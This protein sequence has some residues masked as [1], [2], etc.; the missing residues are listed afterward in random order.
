MRDDARPM[1]TTGQAVRRDSYHGLRPGMLVGGNF[2]LLRQVGAG[3]SGTVWEAQD[4]AQGRRVA[5]KLLLSQL[6]TQDECIHRMRS[7]ARIMASLKHPNI[8]TVYT[9][10]KR[11]D[12]SFFVVQELLEG[13]T[14]REHLFSKKHLSVEETL[15]LVIPMVAAL[16]VVHKQGVLHRDIKP[17]NIFLSESAD[18]RFSPKLIDFGIA[19]VREAGNAQSFLEKGMLFGTLDYMAP[20]Q[21]R[22]E[23]LD[24]RAD[25]WA[26]GVVLFEMLTGIMPF[27][28]STPK[29]VTQKINSGI[30]PSVTDYSPDVPKALVDIV[31]AALKVDLPWRLSSMKAFLKKLIEFS[32]SVN[33]ELVT[34]HAQSL[35]DAFTLPTKKKNTAA[36]ASRIQPKMTSA[37]LGRADR[38]GAIEAIEEI[39]SSFLVEAAPDPL[40]QTG[41][42]PDFHLVESG[43]TARGGGAATTQETSFEF[44]ANAAAEALRVNLL[45]EAVDHAAEA[46]L[47]YDVKGEPMG[48]LLLVEAIASFWLG[49]YK[50]TLSSARGAM[51][52]FEKGSHGWYV[53]FGHLILATGYLGHNDQLRCLAVD[54]ID[55]EP[56]VKNPEAH[57][58]ASCRLLIWLMRA[59]ELRLADRINKS[60]QEFTKKLVSSVSMVDAWLHLAN[61]E[62]AVKQGDVENYLRH[63]EAAVERFIEA[64]DP[65]NA[66]LQR[67]NI[68]N[69]YIQF[70]AYQKAETTLREA[71]V[72]GEPM[73][74][75]FIPSTMAN[76]GFALARLGDLAQAQEIETKARDLLIEQRYSRFV[77]V[78][79][80][81]LA[82]IM[83]LRGFRADA[84]VE[85]RAA[86]QAASSAPEVRAYAL[87]TLADILLARNKPQEAL[88]PAKEAMSLLELLNGVEEGE[89][90]IRLVYALVLKAHGDENTAKQRLLEARRAIFQRAGQISDSQLRRSFLERIPEN[91]RILAVAG[92]WDDSEAVANPVTS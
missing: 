54:L 23:P 48:R 45:N 38:S 47:E 32:F 2:V 59:G 21:T 41:A 16:V 61:A 37:E 79:R 25:V 66:C 10:G 80:V 35:P 6:V 43:L 92:Q 17:E 71:V 4:S 88:A 56:T 64:G 36:K 14:L 85:A 74:L 69:A 57:I 53:A 12:G 89:L 55:L 68:G 39:D 33:P 63:V 27:R 11:R 86:V 31:D 40:A 19:Q 28:A 44:H 9:V 84:E 7:E 30:R 81:Y 75:S 73:K 91:S 87:G 29:E 67:T 8:V 65:R 70:G 50:T 34:R 3:A 62:L 72:V 1:T 52:N 5:L 58:I 18:S 78:S 51:D 90:L 26:T 22:G 82:T 76:L 83:L 42:Y 13:R 77:G 20:E 60:I 15:D 46:R 49:R 24:G